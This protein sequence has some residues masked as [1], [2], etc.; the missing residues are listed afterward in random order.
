MGGPCLRK[1]IQDLYLDA[2]QKYGI[3]YANIG[4]SDGDNVP[5]FTPE[6]DPL[7]DAV[8]HWVTKAVDAAEYM[9]IPMVFFSNFNAS[10]ADTE[11][12]L[13]LTAKRYRYLCDYAADKGIEISC[14]NPLSVENSF[15]W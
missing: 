9:K 13:E 5:F 12:K 6:G 4:C 3:E 10:L 14:E 7:Y 8:N 15:S 1:K 11:E 2:Q